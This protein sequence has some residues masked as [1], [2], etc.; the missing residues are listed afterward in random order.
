MIRTLRLFQFRCHQELSLELA[1]GRNLF[2]GANGQGKTSILEA[3]YFLSRLKSFRTALTREIVAWN[4]SVFRVEAHTDA[5]HLQATW[6]EEGRELMM[7]G[8]PAAPSEFWGRIP[9]VVFTNDDR[10]LV[11]GSGAHRRGWIDALLAQRDPSYLK[12]AQ[13]Y[14]RVLKQRNAWLKQIRRDDSQA[15]IWRDQLTEL[16]Q[17]ITQARQALT[18]LL[19]DILKEV[20]SQMNPGEPSFGI[21]YRP[22]FSLESAPDWGRV[23]AA[24]Y[25]Q[26]QT[27]IGPHRDDWLLMRGGHPIGRFGSEGQQ[28]MAALSLRMAEAILI[29]QARGIWPVLLIDDVLPQLDAARRQLFEKLLPDQAQILMTAPAFDPDSPGVFW[30]IEPGAAKG[31]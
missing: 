20:F 30:Q 4:Q 13:R 5:A 10:I 12:L 16:G 19:A 21:E 22:S 9:T 7:D 25:S 23:A 2:T 28:R 17:Q 26:Q 18:F 27:L 11:T 6:S 3:V 31:L 24:E 1:P 29:Q 8:Q 14:A 15:S